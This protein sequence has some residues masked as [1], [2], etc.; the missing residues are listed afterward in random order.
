MWGWLF[1]LL[2]SLCCRDNVFIYPENSDE[3]CLSLGHAHK[4]RLLLLWFLPRLL[5]ILRRQIEVI[6]IMG[7]L[8]DCWFCVTT[9]HCGW[10]GGDVSDVCESCHVDTSNCSPHPLPTTN[11]NLQV[12]ESTAIHYH[13]NV[14][15]NKQSCTFI[16][17]T[18][19][20]WW[21]G[22]GEIKLYFLLTFCLYFVNGWPIQVPALSPLELPISYFIVWLLKLP[23]KICAVLS[24]WKHKISIMI[25][26]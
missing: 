24:N 25:S 10:E 3:R 23:L 13:L 20:S 22:W 17:P 11:I 14:L 15:S 21:A 4:R 26:Q 1:I 16:L 9:D 19:I 8:L 12:T 6:S 5:T 7:Q 18:C 2:S